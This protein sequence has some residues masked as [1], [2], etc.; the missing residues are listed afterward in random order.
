MRRIERRVGGD[1]GASTRRH[2]L[3]VS[4]A[5]LALGLAGCSGEDR[6]SDGGAD[7]AAGG[8]GSDGGDAG[9]GAGT[10]DGDD[11]SPTSSPTPSPTPTATPTEADFSAQYPDAWAGDPTTGIVIHE[12]PETEFSRVGSL[13]IRGVATNESDTDY[14][15]VQF[16][17]AVYDSTDAKVADGFAN[18]SGLGAGRRWRFEA[19]A[20]SADDADTYRLSDITAY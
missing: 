7:G 15:Y 1:D 8:D 4:S 13:Y 19:L 16:E 3:K 17:F 10:G 9:D 11:S 18:T 5:A 14:D 12:A 6:A 20:A 2:L